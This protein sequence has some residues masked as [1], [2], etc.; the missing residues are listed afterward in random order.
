MTKETLIRIRRIYSIL[1]SVVIIVAG[2]CLIAGCI[3]IYFS[4]EQ[5]FSREVVAETFSG[6][7]IWIYLSLGMTALSILL[8]IVLLFVKE[9]KVPLKDKTNF[10]KYIGGNNKKETL[11]RLT[12]LFLA[13][14]F[15]VY[16]LI[17]GGTADVLTKAINICTECIGLG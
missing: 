15:V 9:E 7:A 2:L 5:P 8:E 4:G 14:F 12:I 16:G 3:T 13:V 6:I 11:L 17:T 10:P 1:L